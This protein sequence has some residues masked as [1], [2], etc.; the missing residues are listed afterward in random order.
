MPSVVNCIPSTTSTITTI[1][2][3]TTAL[4]AGCALMIEKPVAL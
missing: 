3:A 1:G 4:V 2:A